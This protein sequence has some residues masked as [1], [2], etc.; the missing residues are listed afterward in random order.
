MPLPGSH[1]FQCL[2]YSSAMGLCATGCATPFSLKAHPLRLQYAELRGAV[3]VF[4]V[5][6]KQD[7]L[8]GMSQ[9][10]GGSP[11]YNAMLYSIIEFHNNTPKLNSI[12]AL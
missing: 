9:L 10:I 7:I 2:A 5:S 11:N 4:K 6:V 1:I 3:I 12:T 8:S